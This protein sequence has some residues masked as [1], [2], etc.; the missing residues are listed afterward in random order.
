MTCVSIAILPL[1]KTIK[2]L[3][4]VVYYWIKACFF[5]GTFFFA[6]KKNVQKSHYKFNPI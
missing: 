2:Q 3:S 4:P 1:S 5:F 6:S